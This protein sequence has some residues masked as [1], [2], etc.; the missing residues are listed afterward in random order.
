MNPTYYVIIGFILIILLIIFTTT[1]MMYYYRSYVCYYNASPQCFLDW[2]CPNNT[3]PEDL[4]GLINT[5]EVLMKCNSENS[6]NPKGF[7]TC[8]FTTC[9]ITEPANNF[10]DLITPACSELIPYSDSNGNNFVTAFCTFLYT[11]SPAEQLNCV[12]TGCELQDNGL[13]APLC[14]NTFSDIQ[15]CCSLNC[16]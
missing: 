12:V 7:E 1:A 14:T 15:S 3:Q 11:K 5:N 4:S 16:T 2:Q 10:F 8:V 9:N 6:N 13:P